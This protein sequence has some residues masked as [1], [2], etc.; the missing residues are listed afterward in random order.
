MINDGNGGWINGGNIKGPKGE[1]GADGA[2]GPQGPVGPTGEK[3]EDGAQG[4]TGPK[5]ETGEQGEKGETGE[6]GDTGATGPQG[7]TGENGEDGAQG[8][9]GPKGDTG[10]QGEKGDTGAT[11]PQGPI[12]PTGATGATGEKG[13]K[14][15]T[16]A[17]GPQGPMGPTGPAGSGG[18]GDITKA[19]VEEMFTDYT[20]NLTKGDPI[21]GLAK[22][23]W[24][25]DGVTDNDTFIKR[26]TA[27]EN[28]IS[29][30]PA[31]LMQIKGYTKAVAPM[32]AN[33]QS[34]YSYTDRL[35][36]TVLQDYYFDQEEYDHVDFRYTNNG[37]EM[38]EGYVGEYT[39]FLE[40]DDYFSVSGLLLVGD[41]FGYYGYQSSLS[42]I[43]YNGTAIEGTAPD[44]SEEFGGT[45]DRMYCEWKYVDQEE[46][47]EYGLEAGYYWFME[48][49]TAEYDEFGSVVD[50]I[51]QFSLYISNEDMQ[52]A[53]PT[54]P[55]SPQTGDILIFSFIT[56]Y[57]VG[58]SLVSRPS[59]MVSVD[60]SVYSEAATAST[61]TFNYD[62]SNWSPSIA[63]YGIT[64][65]GTSYSGDSIVCTSTNPVY[66][67]LED[68]TP[69]SFTAL[70]LNSFDKDN[71]VTATIDNV[72][73]YVVEAVPGL[74]DGYVI[75][76]GSGATINGGVA[77]TMSATSITT[78]SGVTT[79]VVNPTSAATYIYFRTSGELGDVC[80]HPQWSGYKNNVYESYSESTVV[81]P[82]KNS[83]GGTL[84]ALISVGN[85]GNIMD[86]ENGIFTQYVEA[87]TATEELIQQYRLTKV[88]GVDYV[89]DSNHIYQVLDTPVEI[90]MEH[91][92]NNYIANDFSIEYF[93]GTSVAVPTVCYYSTNLVDK[94]RQDVL[95]KSNV[96]ECT[97][98][99]YST[100]D[101]HD[102]D[103]TYIITDAQT[104]D[105][106]TITNGISF[107]K[108][109]LDDYDN[110]GTYDSN[111]LYIIVEDE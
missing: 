107:W 100:M 47:E 23:L 14:G 30:G 62:G 7:P 102:P 60:S 89:F 105:V 70:G 66:A 68:T 110:L 22:N 49:Q 80:I 52:T 44:I 21:V 64:L 85:V 104:I 82:T 15:D 61:M 6:K 35:R 1:T 74:A 11:G 51:E 37:W 19:E 58:Y 67:P 95:T 20:D 73:Y 71:P 17:T 18:S 111:T 65:S 46:A 43:T 25:P 56:N 50:Y 98:L 92:N 97:Q 26:T 10:E 99:Q 33:V 32:Y 87:I 72:V 77:A 76:G 53:V 83:T 57:S 75:Y 48:I 34:T 84:P 103:T 54:V 40:F 86:L 3:G 79:L 27:G 42:G 88:W 38:R 31:K 96:V 108:G 8:P 63:T 28:S 55:N 59:V 106:S 45:C 93:N 4:A 24:S 41:I 90:Q 29:S 69:T 13:E 94:L 39:E 9:T 2:T 78:A 5:G 81:L 91:V 109:S 12:G 101:V 16:G 36:V